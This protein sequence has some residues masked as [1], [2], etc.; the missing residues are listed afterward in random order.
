MSKM[1][2]WHISRSWSSGRQQG[3]G[4]PRANTRTLL[5]SG[6]SAISVLLTLEQNTLETSR[7]FL[8]H[9]SVFV[10]R[11]MHEAATSC[12]PCA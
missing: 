10:A 1:A 3:A 12:A 9:S 5:S 4:A 2:V 11:N 6:I 7:S 8:P